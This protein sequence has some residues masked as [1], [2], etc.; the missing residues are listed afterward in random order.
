MGQESFMKI[1]VELTDEQRR[2]LDETARRLNVPL[3]ELASA[4]V[5]DLLSQ[6]EA[7]F[8]RVAARVLEKNRDLYRRLA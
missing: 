1:S 2:R 5:R 3:E 6:G 4:A 7:D 8:E